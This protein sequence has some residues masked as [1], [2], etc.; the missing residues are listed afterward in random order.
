[1]H[2]IIEKKVQAGTNESKV[3]TILSSEL[4]FFADTDKQAHMAGFDLLVKR[5]S[6]SFANGQLDSLQIVLVSSGAVSFAQENGSHRESLIACIDSLRDKME[7]LEYQHLLSTVQVSTVEKRVQVYI[8]QIGSS[9]IDSLA[10]AR[11]WIRDSICGHDHRVTI[12]LPE[13]ADGSQCS[14]TF[15]ISYQ[16]CPISLTSS[17]MNDLV[18]DIECI[19]THGLKVVQ[20]V[21]LGSLDAR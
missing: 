20:R 10:L 3:I 13:T 12:D 1:M 21:P 9:D 4:V 19:A 16:L 8:E 17:Y 2:S 11:R 18:A 7:D 14:V 15:D 5:L 6:P